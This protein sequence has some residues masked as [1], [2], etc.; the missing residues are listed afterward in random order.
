MAQNKQIRWG[1][2]KPPEIHFKTIFNSET[3]QNLEYLTRIFVPDASVTHNILQRT[4]AHVGYRHDVCWAT[5][6][7]HIVTY[8]AKFGQFLHKTKPTFCF[9]VSGY[10]NI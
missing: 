9:K 8:L 4:W 5:N 7:A 10:L 3:I 1:K 6:G 2:M